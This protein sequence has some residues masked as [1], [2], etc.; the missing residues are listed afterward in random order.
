MWIRYPA[1]LDTT[2]QTLAKPDQNGWS[3]LVR[4]ISRAGINLLVKHPF[5][6]GDLLSVELPGPQGQAAHNVLGCIVRVEQE[7]DEW[8]LGCVFSQELGDKE[9]E[10]F[11]AKRQKTSSTDQRTWTRFPCQVKATYQ[12]VGYEETPICAAEVSNISPS[13]I[14]LLV[15]Q[16]IEM[17][18][19][20]N[21]ELQ[22]AGSASKRTILGCVVHANRDGPRWALG[23]NFI[24]EL[25]E[26][27]LQA[28]V[29]V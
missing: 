2:L 19:L 24:R 27:D 4:D 13:G 6:P 17:G 28:L 8:A 3:A 20:L 9:L 21:L 11:G 1:S 15:N 12:V 7:G 5:E 22:Q 10:D 26:D 23:C 18:S 25:S 14:G 29:S 16:P